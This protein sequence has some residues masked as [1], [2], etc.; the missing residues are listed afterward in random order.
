ME[1]AT[2][3]VVVIRRV[4]HVTDLKIT[5]KEKGKRQSYPSEE[6]GKERKRG[7]ANY[8]PIVKKDCRGKKRNIN[9]RKNM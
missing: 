3:K 2:K 9:K 8:T 4:G 7:P 6:G 5:R 1:L